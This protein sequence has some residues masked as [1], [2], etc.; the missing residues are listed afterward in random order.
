MAEPSPVLAYVPQIMVLKGF[1]LGPYCH[2][3]L[4][5]CAVMFARMTGASL[6]FNYKEIKPIFSPLGF[7]LWDQ[8]VLLFHPLVKI[9]AITKCC[10]NVYFLLW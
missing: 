4:P 10:K 5:Q 8:S 9:H 1:M 7:Y 2:S 3:V 6:K